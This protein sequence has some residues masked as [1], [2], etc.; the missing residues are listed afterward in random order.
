MKVYKAGSFGFTLIEIVV[1]VGIIAVIMA[2]ISGVLLGS[3]RAKNRVNYSDLVEEEGSW[4]INE[5]R[6]N[7][8]NASASSVSCGDTGVSFE[9]VKNEG[10]QITELI[11]DRETNKIA[12]SSAHSADLSSERV[13]VSGCDTFVSCDTLPSSTVW[14]VNFDFNVSAGNV[15]AGPGGY[16]SRDFKTSVTVRN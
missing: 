6:K 10:S 14:R 3:F 8:L 15:E 5:L 11:C 12:S 1:V 9:N 7:V 4:I 16:V 13:M 2:S